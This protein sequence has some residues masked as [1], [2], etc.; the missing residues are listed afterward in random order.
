MIGII[1]IEV[2]VC[3]LRIKKNIYDNLIGFDHRVKHLA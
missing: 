3:V 2:G 1:Y